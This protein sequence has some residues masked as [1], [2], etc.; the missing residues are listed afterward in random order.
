[1]KYWITLYF[2]TSV[3]IAAPCEGKLGSFRPNPDG[4]NGGFI[5]EGVQVS[6][7]VFIS[8]ESEICD[9]A[10]IS[11][12]VRI[13]GKSLVKQNAR[14]EGTAQIEDSKVSGGA[15][16]SGG[17]KIVNSIICQ[18][19]RIEGFNVINSSCYC[20]TEDFSPNDP[21]ESGRKTLLGVDSD[22]DGVRDDLEVYINDNLP[23]TPKKNKSEER[24]ASKLYAKIVVR[25]MLLQNNKAEILKLNDLKTDVLNCYNVSLQDFI[26]VNTQDTKER[27]FGVIK[28]AGHLHG[29]KIE[30]SKRACK[31]L[32]DLNSALR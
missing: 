11:G 4:S 32:H 30:N 5:Q 24:T 22:S 1:M 8:L 15:T 20:M 18:N 3:A 29:V 23:N 31:S 28:A 6:S 16:I 7:E 14:I 21:G 27:L 26:F 10:K 19:S 13:I 25:E 2:I 12:R 17:S 9:Q